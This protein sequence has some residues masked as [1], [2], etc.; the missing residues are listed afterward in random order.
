MY[1]NWV[2]HD[3][4]T[5]ARAGDAGAFA[6]L[7]A[8]SRP[9]CV[10]VATSVVKD[11][12]DAEDHVQTA[13]MK[14]W[15]NITEFR[16]DAKFST[17]MTRIVTNECLMALRS[18]RRDANNI[19]MDMILPDTDRMQIQISDCRRTPEEDLG[20]CEVAALVVEEM[21]RVPAALRGVLVASEVEK[22]PI[23][24][25]ADRYGLSLEAAK[26]RLYR[27]RKELKRRMERHTGR[28]GLAT[29][30]A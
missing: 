11:P 23:H 9:M 30:T 24:E 18:R 17:W 26:S 15:Q 3:L 19:S 6:E 4:V 7:V 16:E 27:A 20:A 1:T 25:V 12:I 5:A 13:F 10:K 2:E 29:L 21:N 14:A 22:Q 28:L 8:R